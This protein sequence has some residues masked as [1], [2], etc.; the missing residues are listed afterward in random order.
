MAVSPPWLPLHRMTPWRE[1]KLPPFNVICS[2]ES[3][4]SVNRPSTTTSVERRCDRLDAMRPSAIREIHDMA[5][6]LRREDP[7][8][9][10][11]PLHFGE[12]DLGTPSFIVDAGCQALRSGAV[13]YEDNSGRSDLKEA[14]TV[15][16]R[17]HY[18]ADLHPDQ[19][20]ITCGATQAIALAMLALLAPGD[21]VVLVTPCWPNLAESSRIGGAEVH[22]LPLAFDETRR[23]FELD[24]DRLREMVQQL[25]RPRMIIVNSPSNPTGWVI[26]SEQ[27]KA[28]TELCRQWGLF[29]V[30]DEIYDRIVFGGELFCSAIAEPWDHMV[31]INGFSKTYCMTGWRVGYLIA[32]RQLALRMARMQEFIT[33]HAPSM[34]QVA[35]ITALRDGEE[36]VASSLARYRTLRDLAENE[37]SAIENVTVAQTEGTFYLF[38]RI[39]PP[40]D[41]VAICKD[42]LQH[43]G[44]I[45]APGN[46]FGADSDGWFRICFATQPD[47][48]VKGIERMRDH[49]HGG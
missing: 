34:A 26:S 33:S 44:V 38:F 17:N 13:Y 2:T 15:H 9:S 14:L 24:F 39:D 45:V 3:D 47:Q 21:Q 18:G 20:V 19:F 5:Q 48:L 43:A 27:R 10:L 4:E 11:I 25:D 42:F 36:F 49:L 16:Y 30:S 40:G 32:E 29:L 35:A 1:S 28:L 37:L 12:S 7:S 31:V 23:V 46:A 6:Q 22:E 41:S 8:R